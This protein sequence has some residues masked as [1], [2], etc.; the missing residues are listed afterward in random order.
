MKTKT[1]STFV[2]ATFV[3][4]ATAQQL[5]FP[6]A[7][8]FGKYTTGGRGGRVM[9]VTNLNDSGPGSLREAVESRGPRTVVFAVDGDIHLETPLRIKN[10]SITIAGQSAPGDGICLTD[11]AL[12]VDASN[13][14]VRYLRVRVGDKYASD[15]DGIGGGR[16][17]QKNVILDHLSVSWSIDECL[18]I[19]KTENLTV[20]WCLVTH[21]LRNSKHTKGSHG[22]GGIWGGLKATFHHNLLANHSSRNPRFSSVEGTRSVDHRNNVI[23]NWGFKSAYGGGRHGEINIVGNYYKAGPGTKDP[24]RIFDVSDDGT[25]RYYIAGNCVEGHD[26]VTRDN[27]LGVGGKRPAQALVSEPYPYEPIREDSPRRAYKRV[28]ADVGCSHVRDAYDRSVLEQ[29]K[30]GTALDGDKGFIDTPADVGGLPVLK[31][32]TPRPDTDR[33]GM[34]DEWERRHGLDPNDPSDSSGYDLDNGYTNIEVYL[35]SLVE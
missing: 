17:G 12:V 25:G 23:Y 30:A 13:A 5:A 18:S 4:A 22:F 33:D 2:A 3:C 26:D 20:Q 24:R 31:R 8:G 9:V 29:V 6:G 19:Y 16:Y 11:C 15:T 28:L 32:G 34:P 7:E 1:I 35:N 27:R 10:D 21:S 14:I